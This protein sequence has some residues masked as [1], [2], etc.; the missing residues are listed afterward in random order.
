MSN[1]LIDISD[2]DKAEILAA[3]Y[4]RSHPQGM[5][6][7]HFQPQDMTKEEAQTLLDKSAP[8][9]YFDY[10]RGR[11]MKIDLSKDTISP[12]LY[13]RDLGQGACQ[14]IIDGLRNK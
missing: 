14:S 13:D 7:L 9:Y 1:D 6:I 10:L 11:V 3:L 5:G 2:L 4:N 12:R 8:R